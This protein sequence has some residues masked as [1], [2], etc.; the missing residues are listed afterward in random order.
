MAK[1]S[2]LEQFRPIIE[3]LGQGLHFWLILAILVFDFLT[4]CYVVVHPNLSNF[5]K[6][7]NQ[8]YSLMFVKKKNKPRAR[9]SLKKVSQFRD[10]GPTVY[11]SK[12]MTFSTPHMG[13]S[14]HGLFFT[15]FDCQSNA[16]P[17]EKDHDLPG[18]FRLS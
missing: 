14:R 18:T 16:K 13:H 17:S 12:S 2:C 6:F 1:S 11:V 7:F 4:F 5:N 8:I 10:P 9:Q 3:D 15:R